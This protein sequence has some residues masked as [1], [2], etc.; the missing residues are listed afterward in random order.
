M[1][2]K[3]LSN[4]VLIVLCISSANGF[5]FN[6]EKLSR[7]SGAFGSLFG[8]MSRAKPITEYFTLASNVDEQEREAAKTALEQN[9]VI[10]ACLD[11]G[12]WFPDIIQEVSK[13]TAFSNTRTAISLYNDELRRNVAAAR[14]AG[15]TKAQ[16]T[17]E[18]NDLAQR[19]ESFKDASYEKFHDDLKALK[20][21][22]N[23]L[24]QRFS[25]TRKWIKHGGRVAKVLGPIVDALSIGVNAWV[26]TTSEPGTP[27]HTSAALGIA[28]GTFGVVGFFLSLAA[29]TGPVGVAFGAIG[30]MIGIASTIY[31][32]LT[33]GSDVYT[34][35]DRYKDM[36]EQ[37]AK[38]RDETS[39]HLAEAVNTLLTESNVTKW[40]YAYV[41][42]PA[43]LLDWP[44]NFQNDGY[45]PVGYIP[46]GEI[47][48]WK[49][50][51]GYYRDTRTDS[52]RLSP[53]LIA[54][55]SMW[56]TR[57]PMFDNKNHVSLGCLPYKGKVNVNGR[58]QY[59][60][61]N[62]NC[63]DDPGYKK[64]KI[65]FDFLGL[66]NSA[67]KDGDPFQGFVVMCLTKTLKSSEYTLRGLDIQTETADTVSEYRNGD[68]IVVIDDMRRLENNDADILIR[69]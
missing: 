36:Q 51:F 30:A 17:S 21:S 50:E 9:L 39:F 43:N 6:L 64:A 57:D 27:G 48:N 11:M 67:L 41:M 54:H 42:S 28:A 65:G 18:A 45:P 16:L 5:T 26:L 32:L 40:N 38:F 68:D 52:G 44:E 62:Q 58:L 47:K 15:K 31:G 19:L 12:Y 29:V 3:M 60:R 22:N 14:L 63:A 56:Q 35:F 53:D 10:L 61:A 4:F 66:K 1:G 37:V 49:V 25:K 2:M 34:V 24:Y 59:S 55:D 23:R 33:Q 46:S 69:V 20:T 7:S 8:G 13:S